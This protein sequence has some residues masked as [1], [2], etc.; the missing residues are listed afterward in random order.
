MTS[1]ALRKKPKVNRLTRLLNFDASTR[2]LCEESIQLSITDMILTAGGSA[3]AK[4]RSGALRRAC[5]PARER[6]DASDAL[7]IIGLDEVGRGC[8][9][10]PVVAAAVALPVIDVHSDLGASLARLNDSKMLSPQERNE[11]AAIIQS[12]GTCAIAESSVEEI[13]EFNIL[14]ASLL[15]MRRAFDQLSLVSNVVLLID[16]NKKIPG[17]TARQITVVKGDSKSAAIASASIIAK[18]YRDSLM[19]RLSES[20][21]QYQWHQN[22]GYGSQEHKL[23]IKQFGFTCWHR[24]SFAVKL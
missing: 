1:K 22:K 23:A 13:D 10:G 18:V 6:W 17:L 5:P 7:L 2:K 11:L 16:G 21:P 19:C 3:E 15:A 12:I 20:H 8:L 4:P 9:A 24:K 14:Q